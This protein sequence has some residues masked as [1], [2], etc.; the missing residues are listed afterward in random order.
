MDTTLDPLAKD[1]G[2]A[3]AVGGVSVTDFCLDAHPCKCK[4]GVNVAGA[5]QSSWGKRTVQ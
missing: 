5:L 4:K 1:S 2:G 3:R